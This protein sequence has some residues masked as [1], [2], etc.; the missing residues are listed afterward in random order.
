MPPSKAAACTAGSEGETGTGKEN[1]ARAIHYLGIR[2]EHAFVPINCGAIPDE[3]FESEL[4]GY[5]KGA[6]TDAKGSRAGLVEVAKGGTLFLDEVDSLSVK[7]QAAL[8]RFVQTQEYRP[9]GAKEA[10]YGDVRIV[11]ATNADLREKV[12]DSQFREDLLYRLKVLGVF[13][14]PI[15]ERREDIPCIAKSLL[16][17][18]SVQHG[19]GY[20]Q[21]TRQS[22]QWLLEQPWPGNVREL[23]NLLLR[24]FLLGEGDMIALS[25]LEGIE[26]AICTKNVAEQ[27]ASYDS[28]SNDSVPAQPFVNSELSFQEAKTAVIS[29][30]EKAYVKSA[31]RLAEGNISE[32]ARR[33]GK[34]RRAFGKLVNKYNIERWRFQDFA[35][36]A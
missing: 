11:A 13:M 27:P 4:F 24:E 9:L 36:P 21:L 29:E 5:E 18:M 33:A 15:R 23:E 17:K 30:F 8:L 31:L 22:M 10:R 19:K 14:P 32:A 6:F 35:G 16:R 25:T 28:A 3:L 1:A 2:R 34:E 20:R 7:A 26:H 12:A